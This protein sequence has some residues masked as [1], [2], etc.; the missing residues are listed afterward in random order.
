[1]NRKTLLTAI[2]IATLS[3]IGIGFNSNR[4]MAQD[5]LLNALTKKKITGNF[6][7]AYVALAYQ[8]FHG[9]EY[10]DS[11][12]NYYGCQIIGVRPDGQQ[13]TLFSDKVMGWVDDWN[14][15]MAKKNCMEAQND[16]LFA[17]HMLRFS[18]QGSSE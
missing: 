18:C 5:Y 10:G 12:D 3:I 14:K 1:M 2:T 17:T 15:S 9:K 16:M 6:G 7:V 4:V 13:V 11:G 8:E